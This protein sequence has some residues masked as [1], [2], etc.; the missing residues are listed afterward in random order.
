MYANE[1][2]YTLGRDRASLE[3]SWIRACS[4]CQGVAGTALMRERGPDCQG[5]AKSPAEW[6][7]ER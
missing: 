4:Q 5:I 1:Q 7:G 3:G 2:I 6:V